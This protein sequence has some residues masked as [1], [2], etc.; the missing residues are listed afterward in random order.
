MARRYNLDTD[1]HR[2]NRSVLRVIGPMIMAIG[3]VLMLIGLLGFFSAFGSKPSFDGPPDGIKL[4]FL[5][6]LGL[7]MLAVGGAITKFAYLGAVARYVASEA[8]P[9]AKDTANYMIDGTRD[10]IG[11]LTKTV[12]AGVA[13]GLKGDRPA[14][15]LVPCTGC[16]HAC[17]SGARFCNQCGTAIPGDVRCDGCGAMNDPSARFC[18]Q[19][20]QPTV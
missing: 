6:F 10:A 15:D 7:P 11:D 8:A 4:F 19:C 18:E 12:V 3:G 5:C 13:G 16:G 2:S 17:D 1:K 9:V 20:G 14:E